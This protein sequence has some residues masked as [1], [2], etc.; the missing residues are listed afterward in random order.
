MNYVSLV[1]SDLYWEK[2][3][4]VRN[5]TIISSLL[6]L[7]GGVLLTTFFLRRNYNPLRDLMR[8]VFGKANIPFPRSG[9]EYHQLQQALDRTFSKLDTMAA[10]ME[11]QRHLVRS[12]FIARLLKGQADPSIPIEESLAAFQMTF[13]SDEF[14][15]LLLYVE[16][17]ESFYA[18]L[19][20]M[21]HGARRRLL[22]FIVANVAEELA[23]QYNNGYVA[24]VDDS[25]ALLISFKQEGKEA[26]KAELARIAS[27][28]QL[29]LTDAYGIR[30]TL[31][32]SG[33]HSG[34]AGIAQAYLETLDAMQYKLVMGSEEILS[35]EDIYSRV[36]AEEGDIGYYYPLQIEQQLINYMKI[37]EFEKAKRT[38]D[39]IIGHNFER[40]TVS[41]PF[42]RC[43]MLNLVSTMIKTVIESGSLQGSFL[44]RSP[45][46]IG[47]LTQCDTVQEMQR[48]MTEF[49]RQVCDY[50]AGKRQ[51]QLQFTRRQ[52]IDELVDRVRAFI[53]ERYRDL[54]LNISLI[55]R[56]FDMKP[57]YLSKLYKDHTGEGLLD[58]IN[59]TRIEKAK[60]LIAGE[61][62]NVSDAAGAVGFGDVN[63]FIRTFKKYEGITPGKF[64]DVSSGT[65]L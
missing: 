40:G 1:P 22:Q 43:L 52:A 9:N 24:E 51:S 41:V 4:L 2:A 20:D 35:Y 64:K 34:A 60:L 33:I 15:V 61:G 7:L 53:K 48:E 56:H 36:E 12:H 14:A 45:K 46:R 21:E 25:L 18:W 38:F 13:P 17:S 49:L 62:S 8:A 47:R 19:R 57:T 58:Y 5:L 3:K 50:M 29:F 59:K 6:S 32:I 65:P 26:R 37:G 55:G 27:E 11:Q 16:R 42:A 54:N 30:L 10:Q 44:I 23:S 28:T 31:A 39:D 63:A